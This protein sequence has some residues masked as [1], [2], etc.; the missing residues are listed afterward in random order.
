MS[1]NDD[2]LDIAL[3]FRL[4]VQQLTGDA[5]AGR[6]VNP[7]QAARL[8][9][10]S[11]RLTGALQSVSIEDVQVTPSK[12]TPLQVMKAARWSLRKIQAELAAL[13]PPFKISHTHLNTLLKDEAP[14]P[15]DVKRAIELATKIK[16]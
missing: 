16:L 9:L 8:G 15:A 1:V 10:L 6:P 4:E 13:K 11:K 3:Q 2:L 5:E 12:P 7:A 14:M